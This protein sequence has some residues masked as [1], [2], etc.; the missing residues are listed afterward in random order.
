MNKIRFFKTYCDL[1]I[2][3]LLLNDSIFIECNETSKRL[4]DPNI[5]FCFYKRP[6][7]NFGKT[8]IIFNKADLGE[9][10]S[11]NS[12]NKTKFETTVSGNNFSISNPT[13]DFY[14]GA[15]NPF[16]FYNIWDTYA[17]LYYESI[18][19]NLMNDILWAQIS[20]TY[21][22][23]T[24]AIRIERKLYEL[25]TIF[26][27]REFNYYFYEEQSIIHQVHLPP[28]Y[29][30]PDYVITGKT[31][32]PIPENERTSKI[33]CIINNGVDI[34]D[35]FCSN[36]NYTYRYGITRKF[37]C[38]STA[39]L[40]DPSTRP[41]NIYTQARGHSSPGRLKV[42]R[43][44]F[45]NECQELYGDMKNIEDT[46]L[47][48]Y[49]PIDGDKIITLKYNGEFYSEN[50]NL[51]IDK[52]PYDYTYKNFII[53]S[54]KII[55]NGDAEVWYDGKVIH[56]FK[57]TYSNVVLP[58]LIQR[59]LRL[60][61]DLEGPNP[62]FIKFSEP[63]KIGADEVRN[64]FFLSN[65]ASCSNSYCTLLS[66]NLT[67]KCDNSNKYHNLY[68]EGMCGV[69]QMDFYIHYYELRDSSYL[70]RKYFVL[71]GN[72]KL[73]KFYYEISSKSSIFP[74]KAYVNEEQVTVMKT[75]YGRKQYHYS[76]NKPGNY[77]ISLLSRDKVLSSTGE[78]VYTR[79]HINDFF[80]IFKP[81]DTC[82]Y[83]THTAYFRY[84]KNDFV[85]L[86]YIH[87]YVNKHYFSLFFC[88]YCFWNI[89]Y[90]YYSSWDTLSGSNVIE[91]DSR[92]INLSYREG[93]VDLLFKSRND[94]S[95]P[96]L[97]KERVFFTNVRTPYVT[98]SFN[99][100]TIKAICLLDN[101]KIKRYKKNEY[102]SLSCDNS[103]SRKGFYYCEP[104]A[105]L[106]Y[107]LY[108]IYYNEIKTDFTYI[109]EP[110]ENAELILNTYETKVG[111]NYIKITSTNFVLDTVY[112]VVVKDNNGKVIIYF[113]D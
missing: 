106:T 99:L 80:P 15:I 74:L 92:D 47:D 21:G 56:N 73:I 86:N 72:K 5:Y 60:N 40:K 54:K 112:K 81:D 97:H 12:I 91:F 24:S 11:S 104:N 53:P 58:S 29:F 70:S 25:E 35:Y 20:S 41:H 84:R 39:K 2:D 51:K 107:G 3:R 19:L 49:Y 33:K 102:Y 1:K 61:D 37:Y 85:D 93:F 34:S 31:N 113:W 23:N 65:C 13:K 9:I 38:I 36:R 75:L 67:L 98:Y 109:S 89:F 22:Y 108:F 42:I 28:V 48:F 55:P 10:F 83:Y 59:F 76:T 63:I 88:R 45:H 17:I 50:K 105:T 100:I 7:L 43:F 30:E 52:N 57:I 18:K 44:D 96:L 94:L 8:K 66:D 71:P 95:Y 46:I 4:P 79:N 110:I 82:V 103:L 27:A 64:K 111:R 6:N 69:K 16:L 77:S 101:L 32:M 62:L 14:M 78:I 26:N 90:S 87:Y 68:Y